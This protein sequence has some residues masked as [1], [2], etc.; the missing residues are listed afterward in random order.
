MHFEYATRKLRK[1]LE[2][3]A[4]MVKAYGDRAKRLKMRLGVLKNAHT[5]ADVP[6]EPPPRCHPLTGKDAGNFAVDVTG[7]WRLVFE[8]LWPPD[9]ELA[10]EEGDLRKVTA[11]RIIEVVDY[12][13]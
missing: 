3:D 1:Q 5:L 2:S 10:R 12:H 4:E 9:D 8:P 7:N 13:R 6:C 11:I